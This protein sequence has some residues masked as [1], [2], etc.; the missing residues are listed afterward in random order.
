[1]SEAQ[2]LTI[3]LASVPT[4]VVVLVGILTNNS[5]LTDLRNYMDSRFNDMA[6]VHEANFKM[7]LSKIE[8]VDSRLTRLEE[9]F[10]R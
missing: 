5:R 10:A 6:R 1:M 4:F 8:D 7:L 9:H 3:A 2:M